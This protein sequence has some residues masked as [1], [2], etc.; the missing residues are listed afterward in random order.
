MF[1]QRIFISLALSFGLLATLS[2]TEDLGPGKFASGLIPQ[3]PGTEQGWNNKSTYQLS[4]GNDS[5]ANGSGVDGNGHW[6]SV[7]YGMVSG[8]KSWIVRKSIDKGVSW[9]VVDNFN[10]SPG[11]ESIAQAF[12]A[13]KLG[14]IFVVGQGIINMGTP[15]Y[16]W[17]VRKSSNGG[18]TWAT[19]DAIT[20][21]PGFFNEAAAIA[22]SPTNRIFVTGVI[23][24]GAKFEWP[25]RT[26]ND[27]GNGWSTVS[28]Y[29]STGHARG[30]AA[31]VDNS[32]NLYACGTGADASNKYHWIIAKSS[33]NG[34]TWTQ[35][36]NY[37]M[38]ASADA[39]CRTLG[40]DRTGRVF[41]GGFADS[42][43][44]GKHWIVK[45][46]TADGTSWLIRD[47]YVHPSDSMMAAN[48]SAKS[49]AFDSANNVYVAGFAS[50]YVGA[51]K[52]IAVVRKSTNSGSTWT[53]EDAY[54]PMANLY[55]ATANAISIDSENRIF[56][57]G[58]SWIGSNA[59]LI[60]GNP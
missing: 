12:A 47:D 4:I 48:S 42:G 58:V 39:E 8:V 22:I 35:V 3:S 20:G 53:T 1:A 32:S 54:Q 17:I 56:T 30:Y 13:D 41:A 43:V 25:V 10:Y 7:G 26:S 6:Y 37:Q 23:H 24:D 52:Y 33:D 59:W 49:I 27:S 40:L 31:V 34:A 45:R 14:N 9:S 21:A 50:T 29:S 16:Y 44:N 36:D 18:A 5:G 11:Q 55:D 57:S 38:Q 2:C 28:T 15:Q 46:A 51:Q 19:V 60:R